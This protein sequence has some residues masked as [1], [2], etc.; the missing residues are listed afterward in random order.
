MAIFKIPR[1]NTSNR[2]NLVLQESEIVFDVDEKA[3]YTGDGET[4][5][6]HLLGDRFSTQLIREKIILNTNH[7][8]SGIITLEKTPSEP[9]AVRLI[10]KNGIE[11]DYGEDFT[12]IG[13]DLSFKNLGLDGFLEIDEV[14]Y[15]YYTT[16]VG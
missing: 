16:I 1:I 3:C 10:P 14:V 8:E 6:G 12:I 13:D 11:Q 4:L 7:I 2:I 9:S 5:G 15:I